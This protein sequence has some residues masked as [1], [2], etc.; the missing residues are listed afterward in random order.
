MI[1][2]RI[3]LASE[4]IYGIEISWKDPVKFSF[5]HGGQDGISM[6]VDR[7]L[8]DQNT[9]LLK[10]SIKDAK[11]GDKERLGAIKRLSSFYS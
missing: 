9:E 8:M 2:L 4:L 1:L 6:P 11:L 5:A 7:K 10:N 3:H